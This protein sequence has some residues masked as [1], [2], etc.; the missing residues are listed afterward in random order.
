MKN[1]GP[2][3][4]ALQPGFQGLLKTFAC[5]MVLFFCLRWSF[6]SDGVNGMHGG[7]FAGT[8]QALVPDAQADSFRAQ[9][10]SVFG[11]EHCAPLMV[12]PVGGW[13]L[14]PMR[15]FHS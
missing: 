5:E 6:P 7:G 13:A 3:F 1:S 4:P 10:G 8:I 2:F 15:F 11:A 14:S 12:R 9:L